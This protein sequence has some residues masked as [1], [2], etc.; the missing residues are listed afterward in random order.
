ME[1]IK[2]PT[3]IEIKKG[4]E[5]ENTA[6]V[7]IEPCYPGY[8]VTLGNS[9]RRVLLSSLPGAAV[10]AVKIKGVQHEFSTVSHVKEDMVEIILNLKALRLKLLSGESAKMNLKVKG[11]KV[12]KASD[13]KTPAEIEIAN[14]DQ[15]IAT[16]TN[17]EAELDMEI[18]VG[19]GRGYVPV[20]NREKEKLE[21]G[22]IAIDS[23][24]TPV[25]GVS[26]EVEN[27]RVEQMTNYDKL[28]LNIATDGTITP[29]RAFQ[30]SA[31][32]LVDHFSF[33]S[34]MKSKYEKDSKK[35]ESEEKEK[36]I[37]EV[38]EEKPKEKKKRGRPKKSG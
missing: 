7:I 2:L 30:E 27:V 24:F 38:E 9:L 5:K 12:A 15:I 28:I 6:T 17:K 1:D 31:K 19:V 37:P 3:K 26:F 23:F 8:G 32:I 20:E 21:L 4:K 13:I 16:L 33:L 34:E 25:R 11:E 35:V 36:S 22:T 10:T 18:T 29:E 14:S